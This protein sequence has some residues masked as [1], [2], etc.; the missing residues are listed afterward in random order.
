MYST[1]QLHA[2]STCNAYTVQLHRHFTYIIVLAVYCTDTR[3]YE[4]DRPIF[5]HY[6]PLLRELNAVGWQPLRAAALRTE[7]RTDTDTDTDT[8][9][10]TGTGTGTDISTRTEGSDGSAVFV[11][12]FGSVAQGR[13]FWTL[14]N[15]GT[16]PQHALTLE[17][18]VST[19]ARRQPRCLFVCLTDCLSD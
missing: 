3:R 15:D 16:Q 11:E 10:R 6:V 9:T 4:R 8:R 18:D 2:E 14:R 12:R 19:P 5:R 7:T 17:L 13:L 1:A